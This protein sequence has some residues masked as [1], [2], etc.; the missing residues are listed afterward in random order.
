MNALAQSLQIVGHLPSAMRGLLADR[1]SRAD[2]VFESMDRLSVRELFDLLG[3]KRGYAQDIGYRVTGEERAIG[4][5]EGV[6]LVTRIDTDIDAADRARNI[7]D[8]LRYNPD[9][10]K[11]VPA[12]LPGY[13]YVQHSMQHENGYLD[14]TVEQVR[15]HERAQVK[16]AVIANVAGLAAGFGSAL[17]ASLA[18]TLGSFFAWGFAVGLTATYNFAKRKNFPVALERLNS[19]LKCKNIFTPDEIHEKLS[20]REIV[21]NVPASETPRFFDPPQGPGIYPRAQGQG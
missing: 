15:G 10:P 14:A 19:F 9:Y 20:T 21:I 11:P 18:P 12:N 1:R 6:R 7:L 4:N 2:E 8:G 17:W 16:Q 5:V 3:D 13:F